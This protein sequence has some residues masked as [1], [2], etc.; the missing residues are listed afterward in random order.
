MAK[1]KNTDPIEVVEVEH[2]GEDADASF[3]REQNDA[4]LNYKLTGEAGVYIDPTR[5]QEPDIAPEL[6][7]SPHPDL[8]NPA[9]PASSFSGRALDVSAN[10]MLKSVDEKEEDGKEAAEAFNERLEQREE[11]FKNNVASVEPAPMRVV[12]VEE[13]AD[14]DAATVPALG[15]DESVKTAQGDPS[16]QLPTGAEGGDADSDKRSDNR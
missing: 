16:A 13:S 2:P 5:D 10:P 8:A 7:V 4:L 6:G 1:A 11:A 12:V 9:P 15:S 14:E 3:L